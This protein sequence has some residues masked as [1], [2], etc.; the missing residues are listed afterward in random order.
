MQNPPLTIKV[1]SGKIYLT[2][3][4][5]EIEDAEYKLFHPL[6]EHFQAHDFNSSKQKKCFSFPEVILNEQPAVET[7]DLALNDKELLRLS[8]ERILALSLEEM[9]T[10]KN[11]YELSTTR[12]TRKHYNLPDWPTD[13]ELEII[14]QTW[15]E[16]CKHKIFNATI[17]MKE[18]GEKAPKIIR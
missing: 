9:R 8:S 17:T 2:K 7:V 16:H 14:A 1:A 11:Y 3:T 5:A 4:L 12:Q 10:I 18:D 13:V 6:V 15:S